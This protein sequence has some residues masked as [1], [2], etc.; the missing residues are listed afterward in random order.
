[1]RAPEDDPTMEGRSVCGCSSPDC[2]WSTVRRTEA[3]RAGACYPSCMDLALPLLRLASALF[4]L[5]E[6]A[7]SAS[8]DN[9]WDR[10][11]SYLTLWGAFLVL[12]HGVLSG[13]IG[14]VD[15]CR[16][17]KAQ[18]ALQ[19]DPTAAHGAAGGVELTSVHE[20]TALAPAAPAAAG[21]A[22]A[23]ADADEDWA[24]LDLRRWAVI[25]FETVLPLQVIIVALYWVLL[26]GLSEPGTA[27]DQF[28]NASA[29]G[30]YLAFAVIEAVLGRLPVLWQH[31]WLPLVIGIGYSI[32]NA[33]WVVVAGYN[34]YPVLKWTTDFSGA[35]T[36]AVLTTIGV[37]V[38]HAVAW[39][40]VT[41]LRNGVLGADPHYGG[42]SNRPSARSAAKPFDGAAAA[43]A[44][45][46][47]TPLE[48]A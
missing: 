35:V 42:Q 31:L 17:R 11:A 14:L 16:R 27:Y 2:G 8:L 9:D 47:A 43:P 23:T 19:R 21:A 5:V 12:Q 40:L 13:T 30:L 3:F 1:M 36:M 46:S 44:A 45:A 20:S 34:V 28:A 29:H 38:V 18:L 7:T 48:P 32:F 6:R 33:V 22:A 26:S 15:W 25:T 10:V 4:V 39:A 41:L 37:I 24:S